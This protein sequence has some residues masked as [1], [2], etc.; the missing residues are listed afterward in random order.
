[1]RYHYL[2]SVRA[3]LLSLGFIYHAIPII[4][5]SN[6][7][8]Y[9]QEPQNILTSLGMI[10][11]SFRMQGFYL[12]AGFFAMMLIK[13]YGNNKFLKN[14]LIRLG[15][16]FFFVG[17]TFNSVMEIVRLS[18]KNI[19]WSDPSLALKYLCMISLLFEK[20]DNRFFPKEWEY[21]VNV[22][23]NVRIYRHRK[24]M[25]RWR[26]SSMVWTFKI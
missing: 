12:I 15:I 21:M 10:L 18:H 11:H 1:M 25:L 6:W 20:L 14:R 16:P 7:F 24:K 4:W 9:G 3:L 22:V 19:N 8:G 5:S 23:K 2:D 13:K 17:F 26:D